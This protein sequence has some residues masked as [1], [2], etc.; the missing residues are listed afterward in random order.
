VIPTERRT[1]EFEKRE[2][3]RVILE[4]LVRADPFNPHKRRLRFSELLRETNLGRATLNRA[5]KRMELED[6]VTRQVE[7]PV[8]R[9]VEIYYGWGPEAEKIY[10]LVPTR[11]HYEKL[12]E[13]FSVEV[14]PSRYLEMLGQA[15]GKTLIPVLLESL[16]HKTPI[17]AEPILKEFKFLIARYVVYQKNPE[18]TDL[19]EIARAFTDIEKHP[20]EYK[21][22]LQELRRAI[23]D[24]SRSD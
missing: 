21:R 16:G 18:I 12:A 11:R 14:T 7:A 17:V 2:T 24:G 3:E 15:L 13:K 6:K 1:Q 23:H 8:G 10:P 9:A 4:A 5:L 22:E 20:E 19:R